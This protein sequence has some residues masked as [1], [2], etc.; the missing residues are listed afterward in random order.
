VGNNQV[1][2]PKQQWVD[3]EIPE[4]DPGTIN[5]PLDSS[6]LVGASGHELLLEVEV[7]GQLHQFLIDSGASLSLVKP[8]VSQAEVQPTNMAAKG[9]TGTQLKS[10]VIQII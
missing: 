5:E 10:L 9:I 8:G 7:E 2:T 4:V 3:N 1:V 6:L